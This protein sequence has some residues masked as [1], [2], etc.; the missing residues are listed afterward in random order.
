[1]VEAFKH[2]PCISASLWVL[3]ISTHSHI[4]F[5]T[6]PELPVLIAVWHLLLAWTWPKMPSGG[7]GVT[8]PVRQSMSPSLFEFSSETLLLMTLCFLKHET[9]QSPA[10]F[11]LP[12]SQ[13]LLP[14]SQRSRIYISAEW[15]TFAELLS[16]H[17]PGLCVC[18][19][20]ACCQQS[21][22]VLLSTEGIDTSFIS[23]QGF[24][25]E[26]SMLTRCHC[27][28]PFSRPQEEIQCI[29]VNILEIKG[30]RMGKEISRGNIF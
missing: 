27:L 15:I 2:G 21:V 14:S 19:P 10:H 26:K 8:F 18:I 25:E 23:L 12:G 5:L 28:D 3:S 24:G 7:T 6:I 13:Q 4:H 20:A 17:L 29:L 9:L 1:M 16:A 11:I 22:P 30:A